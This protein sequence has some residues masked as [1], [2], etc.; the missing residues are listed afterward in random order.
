L[1]AEIQTLG[2]NKGDMVTTNDRLLASLESQTVQ[3]KN[4]TKKENLL[5]TETELLRAQL[6]QVLLQID[7]N[8]KKIDTLESALGT[9]KGI[10]NN[11]ETAYN[12]ELENLQR[13]LSEEMT[14]AKVLVGDNIKLADKVSELQAKIRQLEIFNTAMKSE[15]EKKGGGSIQ[16]VNVVEKVNPGST[17]HIKASPFDK[18]PKTLQ[19]LTHSTNSKDVDSKMKDLSDENYLLKQQVKRLKGTTSNITVS[20]N[21]INFDSEGQCQSSRLQEGVTTA[22]ELTTTNTEDQ[23]CRLMVG[24]RESG[25]LSMKKSTDFDSASAF[26]NRELKI[27]IENTMKRLSEA[28][29]QNQSLEQE[30]MMSLNTDTSKL[31]K[32]TEEFARSKKDN[33]SLTTKISLMNSKIAELESEHMNLEKQRNQLSKVSNSSESNI[34]FDCYKKQIKELK[35]HCSQLKKS[36]LSQESQISDKNSEITFLKLEKEKLGNDILD[37]K[38]KTVRL[39][40]EVHRAQYSQRENAENISSERFQVNEEIYR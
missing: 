3:L 1:K 9:Q 29:A 35:G 26:E 16:S 34:A 5:L 6:D 38:A 12:G 10:C 22:G 25:F 27:T 23:K 4:S 33:R 32:L 13:S 24:E 30:K 2:L 28:L 15:L 14:G 20:P 36:N 40:T 7:E 8:R 39:E 18:A 21:S 19:T 31:A 11:N 37:F 17:S